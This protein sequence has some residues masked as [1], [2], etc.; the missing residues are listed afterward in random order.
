MKEH[1]GSL[2]PPSADEAEIHIFGRGYGEALAIHIGDG[3]WLAVDSAITINRRPWLF[4]Y[5]DAIGVPML[6]VEGLFLTHWHTDHIQGESEILAE[7][8]NAALLLSNGGRSQEFI[9]LVALCS[10]LGIHA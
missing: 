9:R 1:Y 6:N 3:K 5:F 8:P 7:A 10:G 4:E 2:S